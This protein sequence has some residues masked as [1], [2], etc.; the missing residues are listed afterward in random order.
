MSIKQSVPWRT[1]FNAN[2]ARFAAEVDPAQQLSAVTLMCPAASHSLP[3]VHRG[4]LE[5]PGADAPESA[6]VMQ[7]APAAAAAGIVHSVHAAAVAAPAAVSCSS[8]PQGAPTPH[9]SRGHST[10]HQ[11]PRRVCAAAAASSQYADPAQP[12][13]LCITS[14]Q[15]QPLRGPWGKV[16]VLVDAG[17]FSGCNPRLNLTL[18]CLTRLR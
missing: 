16:A 1:L 18:L 7:F 12:P 3:A 5:S 11:R 4:A 14:Q 8:D 9:A 17:G 15:W 6:T 2:S 10:T 13:L